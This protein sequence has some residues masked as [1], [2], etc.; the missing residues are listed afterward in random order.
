MNNSDQIEINNAFIRCANNL[1]Q[2]P[3]KY[4]RWE[5]SAENY[6]SRW[7]F[8]CNINIKF[9]IAHQEM[10]LDYLESLFL[11]LNPGLTFG[12]KHKLTYFQIL[13]SIYEAVLIDLCQKELILTE[14]KLASQMACAFEYM[15]FDKIITTCLKAGLLTEHW[16]RYL[17]NLKEIRNIIHL[18][19]SY[20]KRKKL[21][22]GPLFK[23]DLC[24]LHKDLNLFRVF[25][26]TKY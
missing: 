13:G 10:T 20:F 21:L 26:K 19:K 18:S 5:N 25:I 4:K 7:L 16:S 14:N 11:W 3:S 22:N 12:E 2:L 24:E 15:T 9:S 23:K 1:N 6:R 8:L 17:H